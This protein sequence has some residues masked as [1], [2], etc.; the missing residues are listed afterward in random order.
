MNIQDLKQK[1]LQLLHTARS[2]M[3]EGAAQTEIDA[4]FAD[5][6][7]AQA[8]IRNLEKIEGV[9]KAYE[10]VVNARSVEDR[11][12][13][14]RSTKG[15]DEV[16]MD[17]FKALVSGRDLT[18]EQRAMVTRDAQS[19]GVAAD[20]GYAVPTTLANEIVKAAIVFGPMLDGSIFDV[21]TTATGAPLNF[22]TK[23]SSRKARLIGENVAAETVLAKLGQKTLN[24]YKLTTDVAVASRELLQDA[25][26]NI[27]QWL[28]EELSESYGLGANDYLTNGTG[29]NQ[30]AGIVTA[31]ASAGLD[32]AASGAF[33]VDDL[34]ALQYGVNSA[35]RQRGRY[36][37]NSNMEL[38]LRKAKDSTG[39]YIWQPAMVAGT[40]NTVFG[41]AYV[42]NDDMATADAAGEVAAIFG[43]MK[44]Y[45]VRVSR[46]L[47]LTRLN[48]MFALSDQIGWVGF[49][50][51][52][53]DVIQP[54]ALKALKLKA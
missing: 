35:Y 51:I 43:D 12:A 27:E 30:P 6:D 17:A 22:A 38:A 15:E 14:N 10:A 26:V 20:G 13:E 46:A 3:A 31:L 37:F 9:E 29:S 52:D 34:L 18:S 25:G 42:V 7:T 36:M 2:K 45:K 16:R 54:A 8:N 23:A 28:V 49:A 48:E 11:S 32:T 24:S 33:A 41:K 21:V 39:N 50:R 40:P 5:A 53:G 44:G 1:H 19:T 47:G 4:I